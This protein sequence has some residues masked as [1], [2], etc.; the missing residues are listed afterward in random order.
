MDE[1]HFAG[2]VWEK[3]PEVCRDIRNVLKVSGEKLL[4][5]SRER[6]VLLYGNRHC[7]RLL[8]DVCRF[9][10]SVIAFE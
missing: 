2:Q 4:E 7:S 1:D 10:L 6:V 3:D 8:I 9:L 5:G